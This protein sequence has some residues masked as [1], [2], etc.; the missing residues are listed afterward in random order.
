MESDNTTSSLSLAELMISQ[1]FRLLKSLTSGKIKG[2][3]MRLKLVR[4]QSI[5]HILQ[6]QVSC[7]KSLTFCGPWFNHIGRW[8]YESGI[9]HVLGWQSSLI[10]SDVRR[11]LIKVVQTISSQCRVFS[12]P[13][14]NSGSSTA[15][16]KPATGFKFSHVFRSVQVKNQCLCSLCQTGYAEVPDG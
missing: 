3:K 8:K 14:P 11:N 5:L 10:L 16:K 9:F 2:I 4:M 15:V 6:I 13:P 12:A 1:G 7:T